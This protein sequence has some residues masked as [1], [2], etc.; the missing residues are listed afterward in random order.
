MVPAIVTCS[1]AC[2]VTHVLT[3]AG[4]VGLTPEKIET[5]MELWSAFL[6]A[7]I[8]VL[9]VKAIYNRFRVDHGKD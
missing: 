8:G 1:S 9:C 4:G 3:P 6:V 7:A 5:Y 2:T